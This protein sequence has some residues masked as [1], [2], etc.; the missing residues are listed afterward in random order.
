ME[1]GIGTKKEEQSHFAVKS[2]IG[3]LLCMKL[4]HILY[5]HETSFNISKPNIVSRKSRVYLAYD[6][7]CWYILYTEIN[8]YKLY[9]TYSCICIYIYNILIII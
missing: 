5:L 2:Y 8:A 9:I 1:T 3:M 6:A 7:L 4:L